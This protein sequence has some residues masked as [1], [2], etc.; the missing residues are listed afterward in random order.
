MPQTKHM[1]VIFRGLTPPFDKGEFRVHN[2]VSVGPAPQPD[3]PA[4]SRT[5]SPMVGM[6]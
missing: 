5:L 6:R 1:M 3:R 4:G 2:T